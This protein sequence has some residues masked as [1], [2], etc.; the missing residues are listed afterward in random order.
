MVGDGRDDALRVRRRG[1]EREV[2]GARRD[3]WSER[4]LEGFGVGG[5]GER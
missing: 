2:A 1:H 5:G 3:G 4:E